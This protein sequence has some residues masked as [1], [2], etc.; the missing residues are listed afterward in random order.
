[1]R[2]N[3]SSL[4]TP[5]EE[6]STFLSTRAAAGHLV[7]G[8]LGQEGYSVLVLEAGGPTQAVLGGTQGVAGRWTS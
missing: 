1:M 8:R 7:A 3:E 5:V 4:S 2:M 6:H